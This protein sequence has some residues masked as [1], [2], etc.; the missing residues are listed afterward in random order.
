M[1]ISPFRSLNLL[2][3]ALSLTYAGSA[4]ADKSVDCVDP[5]IGKAC[6]ECHLGGTQVCC[7]KGETCC[8]SKTN[9]VKACP[10]NS[11]DDTVSKEDDFLDTDSSTLALLSGGPR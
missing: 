2:V 5:D 1:R 8:V 9:D 4:A 11:P 10:P 7:P 6:L 3:L